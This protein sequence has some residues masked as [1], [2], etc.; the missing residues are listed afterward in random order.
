M[1]KTLTSLSALFLSFALLCLSHGLQ[2]T[3]LGV[4]ATIEHFPD[5][6]IGLMMSGYFIGFLASTLVVPKIIDRVGQ[7]RTFA[8]SA[9]L[10]SSTA[11]LHAMV[12]DP[13]AWIFFRLLHGFSMA[14][15]YVVIESWLNALSSTEN[16]GRVFSV[17]MLINFS[18]LSLGQFFMLLSSPTQFTLFAIASVLSSF[19]LLPL[20]LSS[21]TQQPPIFATEP[22]PLRTL[23]RTSPLATF[24]ALVTGLLAGA[25]WG[26]GAVYFAK[27]GLSPGEIAWFMALSFVGGLIFQWPIG[28]LSDRYNRRIAIAIGSG[29]SVAT[30]LL[31]IWFSGFAHD[32]RMGYL[33]PLAVIFGGFY[34]PLYSLSIALANDFLKPD[35]FTQ[36]SA[37][38]LFLH[39]G[40]AIAGPILAALFMMLMGNAGLFLFLTLLFGALLLFS[41][42]RIVTGRII[43]AETTEPFVPLP[44]TATG[45]AVLDPRTEETNT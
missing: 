41:M 7:I 24:G 11:L 29:V 37:A 18:C 44:R 1:L 9:S 22:L 14:C 4:R 27:A 5:G 17:Y 3:L 32:T 30:S 20:V 21:K 26:M 39:G 42:A 33:L 35:Q 40:G 13:Y 10:F 31:V 12:I 23:I 34:Y 36:A 43:P 15:L 6:L 25:F 16:R 28:Y 19:S 38:L 2:N 8:A 45:I